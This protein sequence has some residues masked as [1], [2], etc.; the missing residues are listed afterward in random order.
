MVTI[1]INS[2]SKRRVTLYNQNMTEI[3]RL[4]QAATENMLPKEKLARTIELFN[5]TREY[6]ARRIKAEAPTA[7]DTKIKLLVALRMYGSESG[8]KKLLESQL[9]DVSD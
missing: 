4:Y 5:W 9:A 8:M 7:S 6:I 2:L 3:E 1:R